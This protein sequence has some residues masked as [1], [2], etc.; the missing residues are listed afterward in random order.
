LRLKPA[1]KDD[2]ACWLNSGLL[3]LG[4]VFVGF[5]FRLSRLFLLASSEAVVALNFGDIGAIES[6]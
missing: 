4:T 3:P 6:W 5:V 1:T 2:E